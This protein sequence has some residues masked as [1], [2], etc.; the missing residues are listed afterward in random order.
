VRLTNTGERPG[1]EVVQLYLVP[2]AD[3]ATDELPLRALAGFAVVTAEPGRTVEAVIEIPLRAFQRWGSTGWEL[4]T[5]LYAL[6]AAHS[7]GDVRAAVSLEV[8]PRM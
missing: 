2:E 5:G 6:Q 8:P 3:A 4:R 1:R 7:S